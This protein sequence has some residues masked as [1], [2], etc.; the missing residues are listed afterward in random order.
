[1]ESDNKQPVATSTPA[2]SS[3][4]GK[5]SNRWA[6]I[7]LVVA[8][9]A[10]AA[11]AYLWQQSVLQHQQLQQSRTD[12]TAAIQRLDSQ[13]NKHSELQRELDQ[14]RAESARQQQID[15]QNIE[16]LQQQQASQQKRLLAMSTTDRD[17]WLLAEVEYLIRLA[18]QRLLMGKEVK[19]AAD[20][21]HAADEIVRSLN[22]SAL[23]P[24]RKALAM[25]REALRVAGDV[26]IE[27][28][29]LRIGAIAEQ[30]ALLHLVSLEPF[31]PAVEEEIEAD[32][33]QQRVQTG[34]RAALNKL[35]QFIQINR[36]D[37][38]YQ[39][40]LSPEY[41]AIVRQNIQLMFEQAQLAVLSGKQ[42]MYSDSLAKAKQWLVRYYTLDKQAT[43]RIL[44]N[45]EQVADQPI[46]IDLPDIS[47][48]LRALNSY[49]ETIH[50]LTPQLQTDDGAVQ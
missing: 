12:I 23:H 19:G 5:P 10:V 22:D 49:L 29:Y 28:I 46:T 4:V 15:Q 9:L 14:Q 8:L 39:P 13:L 34:F 2:A 40:R 20:L 18:N 35:S 17:D 11:S 1:M 24:V 3:K 31:K 26:D 25:D 32:N 30:A 36:R 43:N 7:S 6:F 48:S 41:E 47:G 21:L 37:E 16:A 38:I 44:A 42:T 27:G 45:I 50:P 33:W